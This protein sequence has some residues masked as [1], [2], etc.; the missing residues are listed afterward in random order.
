MA[1]KKTTKATEGKIINRS[2]SPPEQITFVGR[3]ITAADAGWISPTQLVAP[4]TFVPLDPPQP[5][6]KKHPHR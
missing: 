3:R 6:P 1:K 4:V 5:Q 2:K